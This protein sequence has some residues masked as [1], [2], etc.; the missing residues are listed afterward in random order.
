MLVSVIIPAYN[1]EDYISECLNSVLKQTYYQI[2]IICIDDGSVDKTLSILEQYSSE[3]RS[4]IQVIQ[5]NNQGAP[6]ARN[7][8][9][10]IAKG[11]YIQFLDADDRLAPEK[12][13]HQV[14]LIMKSHAK[15]G[16]IAGAYIR[17]YLNGNEERNIPV[18]AADVWLGLMS[19]ELGCTCS[20][21]FLAESL[22]EINGW[23]EDFLGS[24][25]TE[26]MFRLLKNGCEP[27]IDSLPLTLVY[28][29]K[30]G[31][32]STT[33][34]SS[35]WTNYINLRIQ[36]IKFFQ[37]KNMFKGKLRKHSLQVI[38]DS[39]RVLYSYNKSQA[40]KFH[41]QFIAGKYYPSFSSATTK[42]YLFFYRMLGFRIAEELS[43][44][45]HSLKSE[46]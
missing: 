26:L 8:G 42:L 29:R 1:V 24:Q 21:L 19:A 18:S 15:V 39:V 27:L 31:S 20:N 46:K 4:R 37:E 7:R 6:S 30:G 28:N 9:L 2:E 45:Y 44:K 40:I 14:N 32:V 38:F 35:Y 36:I 3:H 23:K 16:F 13:E 5:Q 41:T 17:K 12:I 33:N 43:R 10:E 22:R 25:E 11:S 34:L